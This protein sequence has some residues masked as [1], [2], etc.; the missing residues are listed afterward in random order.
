MDDSLLDPPR[1]DG[2]DAA[3][4]PEDDLE[5]AAARSPEAM[6]SPGP[7]GRDLQWALGPNRPTSKSFTSANLIARV[8]QDRWFGWG[9][10]D[11][12]NDES[13]PSLPK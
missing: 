6:L 3:G 8:G 13:L 9:G 10:Q 12:C 5:T 2:R 11:R 4:K 7:T 1:R